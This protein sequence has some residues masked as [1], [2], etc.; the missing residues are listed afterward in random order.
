MLGWA[1]THSLQ[2]SRPGAGASVARAIPNIPDHQPQ[3]SQ[4]PQSSPCVIPVGLVL[5][6]SLGIRGA[7]PLLIAQ[8][9]A[10]KQSKAH[11]IPKN[12][13]LD[14]GPALLTRPGWCQPALG[15]FSRTL[16]SPCPCIPAASSPLLLL[17]HPWT[18]RELKG[19]D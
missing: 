17:Q 2:S 5:G 16:H 18:I 15:L 8:D 3:T 14:P 1:D 7:A 12:W 19:S 11:H 13:H 9:R 4:S 10:G 6:F